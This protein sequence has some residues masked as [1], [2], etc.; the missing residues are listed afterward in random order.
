VKSV[1]VKSVPAQWVVSQVKEFQ[2]SEPGSWRFSGVLAVVL[3]FFLGAIAGCSDKS[4]RLNEGET[5]NYKRALLQKHHREVS[6]EQQK[7]FFQHHARTKEELDEVLEEYIDEFQQ[8]RARDRAEA[9][10]A[11]QKDARRDAGPGS[12]VPDLETR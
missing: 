1:P 9:L 10:R 4:R 2:V 8:R 11:A 7:K 3:L 5:Q 12:G 6:F